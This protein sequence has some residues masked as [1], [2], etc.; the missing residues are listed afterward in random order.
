ME[1]PDL[2]ESAATDAAVALAGTNADPDWL[3][4]ARRACAHVCERQ[5]FF[6]A[7]DVAALLDRWGVP[8]THEPRAMGAVLRWAKSARLCEPTGEYKPTVRP[9]G[10]QAPKRVWRSLLI[11]GSDDR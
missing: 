6:T 2:F 7:D 3:L 1:Q 4:A 10:H 8:P 11:G 9:Q 5:D